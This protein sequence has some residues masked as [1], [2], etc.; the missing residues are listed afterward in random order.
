MNK[1]KNIFSGVTVGVKVWLCTILVSPFLLEFQSF[2][3]SNKQTHTFGDF[4]NRM[5]SPF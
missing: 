3:A 4:S 2:S 1:K 5:Y